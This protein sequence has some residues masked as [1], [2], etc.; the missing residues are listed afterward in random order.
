M[1]YTENGLREGL[2]NKRSH[3]HVSYIHNGV[4][5]AVREPIHFL[6]SLILAR[7]DRQLSREVIP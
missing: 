3:I 4:C 2:I 6:A 1:D 5:G 7:P